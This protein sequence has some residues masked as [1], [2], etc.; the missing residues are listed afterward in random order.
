MLA[1]PVPV[2]LAA[3]AV[4][5]AFA[6]GAWYASGRSATAAVAVH[7]VGVAAPDAVPARRRTA[8]ARALVLA[9]V[10]D[11]IVW[12]LQ[13][14]ADLCIIPYAHVDNSTRSRAF[15]AVPNRGREASVYLRFILDH[16]DAATGTDNLPDATL[17]MHGHFSPGWHTTHIVEIIRH[18]NWSLPYANVNYEPGSYVTW[19]QLED[20]DNTGLR[21]LYNDVRE[22][23]P[24]L[25]ADVTGVP[26]LPE[27]GS[28]TQ[29]C[30]AQFL[31]S[32]DN[33]RRH[34]REWYE[35]ALAYLHS[36]EE[37]YA[38]DFANAAIVMEMAWEWVF[39]E[40]M[41]SYTHCGDNDCDICAVVTCCQGAPPRFA[42]G[43]AGNDSYSAAAH[44]ALQRSYPCGPWDDG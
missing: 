20:S 26:S 15:E 34:P 38:G 17:F 40:D 19:V 18:L 14:V 41:R 9:S 10:G 13:H 5:A 1:R 39:R 8:P 11:E 43:C 25:L 22:V 29:H 3:L 2:W 12:A 4:A 16:W 24:W 23:W 42:A 7:A 6:A 31:L 21:K 35:R 28:L 33:I 37:R 44:A 32:R 27:G 36:G 30:C